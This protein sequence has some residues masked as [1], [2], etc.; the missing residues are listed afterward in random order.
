MIFGVPMG[1]KTLQLHILAMVE[2]GPVGMTIFRTSF[3]ISLPIMLMSDYLSTYGTS[4]IYQRSG[5]ARNISIY[6]CGEGH[7]TD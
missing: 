1:L 6:R 5:I 4:P 2:I 7:M 3:L